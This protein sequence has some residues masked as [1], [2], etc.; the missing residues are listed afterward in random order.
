MNYRTDPLGPR[1]LKNPGVA[2]MTIQQTT[3]LQIRE[4][5]APGLA[6]RLGAR[7][8]RALAGSTAAVQRQNRRGSFLVIVVGTLALV[9]VFAI[10]YI[11]IGRG[12]VGQKV[13]LQR[14]IARDDIPNQFADYVAQI[15]ADN[16]V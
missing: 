13:G 11:A 12:D 10:I 6:R 16:T 2:T 1:P 9:S 5:G 8:L 15:I 3:A 4:P 7:L 14:N